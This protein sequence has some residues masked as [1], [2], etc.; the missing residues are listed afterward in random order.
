MNI[1]GQ[2]GRIRTRPRGTGSQSENPVNTDPD[3]HS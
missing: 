1:G 3:V 2:R